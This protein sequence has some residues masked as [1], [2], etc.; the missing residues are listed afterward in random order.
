HFLYQEKTD[1]FFLEGTQQ[2]RYL[3]RYFYDRQE[4][5][6]FDSRLGRHMAV[7]ELGQLE[8]KEWNANKLIL[9]MKRAEVDRFCGHNYE[10]AKMG[11]V[12][13]RR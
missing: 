3:D 11:L 4:F 1:C 12:V 8:A 2:V 13:G 7:T 9:M 6:R 5:V 10:V